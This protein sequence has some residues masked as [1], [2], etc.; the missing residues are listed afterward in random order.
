MP[1]VVPPTTLHV[2]LVKSKSIHFLKAGRVLGL[3]AAQT[4]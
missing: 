2:G 1:Q 4:P 3:A